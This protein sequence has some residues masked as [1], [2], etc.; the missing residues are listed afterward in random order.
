MCFPW[1]H[2]FASVDKP[3]TL[4]GLQWKPGIKIWYYLEDV[5]FKGNQSRHSQ[6]HGFL[7]CLLLFL[8]HRLLFCIRSKA[9]AG[10]PRAP[11]FPAVATAGRCGCASCLPCYWDKAQQRKSSS[12]LT[13]PGGSPAQKG[14]QSCRS[15]L[16][17]SG[18][19]SV[20]WSHCLN[21]QETERDELGAQE[22]SSTFCSLN[23]WD[24]APHMQGG[25]SHLN[26]PD[27]GNASCSEVSLSKVIPQLI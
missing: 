19:P 26:Q 21:C 13:A 8:S 23:I 6:L 7:F 14:G 27:L 18:Q 10:T 15:L 3:H 22:P 16:Q 12:G 5:F 4:W 11:H 1:E 17:S 20:I 24:D 9:R 25:S 2:K